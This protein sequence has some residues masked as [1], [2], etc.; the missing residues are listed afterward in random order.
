MS[1]WYSGSGKPDRSPHGLAERIMI[2]ISGEVSGKLVQLLS[3]ERL[4]DLEKSFPEGNRALLG[5]L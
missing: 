5:R 3:R 1:D 2:V 4:C